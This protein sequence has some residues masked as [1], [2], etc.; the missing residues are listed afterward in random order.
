MDQ[1]LRLF[2]HRLYKYFQ[3]V[4]SWITI[5]LMI[6]SFKASLMKWDLNF[7]LKKMDGEHWINIW[8]SLLKII[9]FSIGK[10]NGIGT[11]LWMCKETI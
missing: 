6:V 8:Y 1:K 10:S 7:L 11:P 3:K 2:K 4:G 9:M 5:I